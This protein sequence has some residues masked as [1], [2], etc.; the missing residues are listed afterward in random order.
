[1]RIL[2]P[3]EEPVSRRTLQ[4]FLT[5]WGYEVVSAEYGRPGWEQP[6]ASIMSAH[7]V[8]SRMT[9]AVALNEKE[10]LPQNEM[11][12]FLFKYQSLGATPLLAA[13]EALRHAEI[14]K[15]VRFFS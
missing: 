2:I 7:L 5:K 9:K 11:K 10:A 6:N 3:D 14:L 8:E 4:G 12:T 13:W 15:I 1:M